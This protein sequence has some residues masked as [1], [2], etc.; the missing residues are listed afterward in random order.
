MTTKDKTASK[1]TEGAATSTHPKTTVNYVT[2]LAER[3]VLVPVGAG[4]TLRDDLVSTVK[5]LATRYH[6]R[7][8]L[9]RELKRFEKRGAGARKRFERRVTRRRKRVE[10]ELR[11]RRRGV[12]RTVKQN[13]RRLEREVRQVRKDLE[14]QST[15]IGARVGGVKARVEE[16]VS[17]AQG[18]MS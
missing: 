2:E 6:T 15:V 4:L 10:R 7:A 5:G 16:L 13:R 8:G 14:K 1:S 3:A 11:Q 18:S 9:E 12:E 17:N